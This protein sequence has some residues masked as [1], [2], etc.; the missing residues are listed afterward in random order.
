M[1]APHARKR[2]GAS[3]IQS[4]AFGDHITIDHVVTRDLRDHGL[5]SEKVAVVVRDVFG[6]FRY[7]YPSP[8]RQTSVMRTSS[9]SC[10]RETKLE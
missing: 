9:I 6:K 10:K 1:L 2:G 3:T 4:K 5:D 7:V 8:R